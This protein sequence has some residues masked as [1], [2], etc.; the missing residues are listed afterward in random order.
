MKIPYIMGI[1]NVTPDSFYDG[2]LYNTFERALERAC[3]LI[4]AGVDILDIGGESTRPSTSFHHKHG[5]R[6]DVQSDHEMQRV[7]PLLKVLRLEFP[8]QIL[9]VDTRNKEL[10][11][12]ALK[13]GVHIINCV[14]E[15]VSEDIAKR[16]ASFPHSR[17][18][19]CHMRGNPQDMQNGNFYEGPII[20]Y[21]KE[22]FLQEIAKMK[23]FG[24]DEK[25]IILDP[26]I[27]FGKKK[28]DQDF[29]I[30]RGISEL[31]S[32]EYPV[33]IGLSRKSFMGKVLN[34]SADQLLSATLAMNTYAIL[35]GADIIR[36]HDVDEHKEVRELLS[37]LT[38][39]G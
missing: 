36:V 3:T 37:R 27:G 1:L 12:E 22:W 33:L 30:L 13:L 11:S 21:L 32:L 23:S 6:Q 19:L 5:F 35:Q 8:S 31:K 39:T 20:P 2:N 18:V 7:L 9:S 14:C 16:I 25:Q 10:A 34:K 15:T 17:C 28:P 38:G 4:E 24:V 26:G 29:E